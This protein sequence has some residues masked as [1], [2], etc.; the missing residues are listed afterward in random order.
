MYYNNGYI[1]DKMERKQIIFV[2]SFESFVFG[3]SNDGEKKC[4]SYYEECHENRK[5][6][7]QEKKAVK[8]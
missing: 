6:I 2:T 7:F 3:D 8:F 5:K 1:N 4:R